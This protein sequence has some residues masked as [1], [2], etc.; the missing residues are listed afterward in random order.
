MAGLTL[1]EAG[2]DAEPLKFSASSMA[3]RLSLKSLQSDVVM[4][5]KSG[6]SRRRWAVKDKKGFEK[7]I[8]DLGQLN[9]GLYDLHA[10]DIHRALV[11]D[12]IAS[13]IAQSDAKTL[14]DISRLESGYHTEDEHLCLTA[15]TTDDTFPYNSIPTMATIAY[16]QRSKMSIETESVQSRPWE[17]LNDLALSVLDTNLI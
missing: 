15:T 5:A 13:L 7:L 9:Q 2:D 4:K 14:G 1:T 12:T 16:N 11:R 6:A 10:P 3:K 17:K 8:E